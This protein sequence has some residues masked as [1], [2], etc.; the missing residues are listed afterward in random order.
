MPLP[1]KARFALAIPALI[2]LLYG[3]LSGLARLGAPAPAGALPLVVFHGAL[4]IGGFFGTVI[5]LERA[6][7]LGRGWPF[8]APLASALAVFA[9][10]FSAADVA[11]LLLSVAAGVMTFACYVV[12]RGQR[13]PHLATLVI[14]A[15]AWLAGNLIWLLRGAIY[16]VVPLWAAFLLLTIA[17]ERLELSRLVPTPRAAR[18]VF[19]VILAV[20]LGA[21]L[22]G[23][24]QPFGLRVFAAALLA[25]AIWLLRYDIARRTVRARSL[26][27]Y[28]A[29]CLL[30]GYA[31]L[32]VAG[33]LGVFGAIAADSP[34]R[35]AALHALLLG[36][37]FAMVFGHAPVIFP[38][39]TQM[40]MRWRRSFYIPLA[41]LHATVLL[42]VAAGLAEIYWLR[43]WAAIGNGVALAVFL[44]TVVTS[45]LGA[46]RGGSV[47]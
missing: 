23:I 26:T 46:R 20:L 5:G 2:A 17:G 37:V 40:K 33:L 25:L 21:A 15:L 19:M 31:W 27:R 47:P 28:M 32:A 42:R 13:E 3:V 35:D 41:L 36:F 45:V 18:R 22:I 8:L 39:V 1:A 9:L 6:V 43:Q 24:V 11:A 16:E 34:L 29:I 10:L 38:A 7:A 30:S 44:L 4:M 12:W 14:A